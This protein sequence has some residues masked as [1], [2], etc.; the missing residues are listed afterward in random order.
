MYDKNN[1]FKWIRKG[2]AL[3][4]TRSILYTIGEKAMEKIDE[5]I[6]YIVND[7]QFCKHPEKI[8]P[9]QFNKFKE[10]VLKNYKNYIQNIENKENGNYFSTYIFKK[11]DI[12]KIKKVLNINQNI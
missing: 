11:E 8:T 10:A 1:K 5:V 6:I 12:I 3:S 7:N 9:I 4:A 2:M